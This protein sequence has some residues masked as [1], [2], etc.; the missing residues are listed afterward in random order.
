[1]DARR[2]SATVRTIDLF[3]T[4]LDLAG[5]E[6]SSVVDGRSLRDLMLAREAEARIAFVFS[7]GLE[8]LATF[9]AEQSF[10]TSGRIEAEASRAIRRLRCRTWIPVIR[11]MRGGRR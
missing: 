8:W 6:A 5:V 9:D 1:M 4:I 7:A 10:S 11:R 3:P 2:E